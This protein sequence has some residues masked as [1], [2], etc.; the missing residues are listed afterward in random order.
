MQELIHL[1]RKAN[2][3]ISSIVLWELVCRPSSQCQTHLHEVV[4]IDARGLRNQDR[5]EQPGGGILVFPPLVISLRPL[6]QRLNLSEDG[7]VTSRKGG[8][9]RS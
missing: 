7:S 9:E 6:L 2:Q 8:I 3:L 5:L 1:L 4:G